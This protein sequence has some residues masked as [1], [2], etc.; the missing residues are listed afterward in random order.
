MNNTAQCSPLLSVSQILLWT[1]Q[2]FRLYLCTRCSAY[3][4]PKVCHLILHGLNSKAM[5]LQSGL[6]A[7]LILGFLLGLKH[8]TDADHIVAVSTIASEYRNAWRGIWVGVSWGLGHTFPLLILGIVVLVLKDAVLDSYS[9]VAP[10]L[11]LLV[12]LMLVF[13][14]VQVFWNLRRGKLHLH[15]HEH[16]A[17]HLHIHASHTKGDQMDS[18]NSNEAE[19]ETA[20][21]FFRLK[22]FFVG[23]VHGLAGSAAI[24]LVLLPQVSSFTA[25]L[26]YLV[27]FGIG[28]TFSMAAITLAMGIPFAVSDR[29]R[30]AKN[31][32]TGIAGLASL[33]FGL[34]LISA[35]TIS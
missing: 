32:V 27:M 17:P 20:R 2:S 21:P 26:V 15:E 10:Y 35:L 9:A 22:S 12:G 34:F 11:E 16:G 19:T 7:A 1:S 14:G 6:L 13:L 29:F 28:T 25:G 8:A 30:A 18:P 31:G 24:V 3:E 23:T 5:E 33:L 4:E